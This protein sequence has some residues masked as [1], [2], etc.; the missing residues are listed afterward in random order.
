MERNRGSHLLFSL[1][2]L[3]NCSKKREADEMRRNANLLKSC[4][5]EATKKSTGYMLR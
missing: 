1:F 3:L 4:L 5:I 2:L